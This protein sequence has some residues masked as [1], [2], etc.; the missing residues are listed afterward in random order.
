[1]RLEMAV[2]QRDAQKR[3]KFDNETLPS[4]CF[5]TVLNGDRRYAACVRIHARTIV[6]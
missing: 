4:V 5:Y 2:Q 3:I 1:M 6:V